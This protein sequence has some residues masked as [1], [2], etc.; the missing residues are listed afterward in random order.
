MF[1]MQWDIEFFE[2]SNGCKPV[3]DFIDG[4]P[5]KDKAKIVKEIELLKDYGIELGSPRAR[6]ITGKKYV[7]LWELRIRFSSNYYR[8]FYF[9]YKNGTFVLLHG[10]IKKK[11]KTDIRELEIAKSRMSKYLELRR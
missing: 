11:N 9:L 10:F 8:I 4:L 1:N 2:L 3:L 6:K 5:T 7:G